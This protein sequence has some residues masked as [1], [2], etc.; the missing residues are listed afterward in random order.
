MRMDRTNYG[1]S[2]RSA[3]ENGSLY[4]E[5]SERK[6]RHFGRSSG[7]YLRN[8]FKNCAH[9]RVCAFIDEG[10]YGDEI[11]AGMPTSSDVSWKEIPRLCD[12]YFAH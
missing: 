10:W 8:M 11:E 7:R 1:D 6:S 5:A 9:R 3:L 2:P 12:V 4:I